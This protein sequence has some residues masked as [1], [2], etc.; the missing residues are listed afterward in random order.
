MRLPWS[1]PEDV[2]ILIGAGDILR[3]CMVDADVF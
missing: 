2:L 1:D 3:Y